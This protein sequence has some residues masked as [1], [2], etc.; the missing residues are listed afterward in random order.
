[1]PS[2]KANKT[3]KFLDIID[4]KPSPIR[5]V[6]YD[7]LRFLLVPF[8]DS[9]ELLYITEHLPIIT[10]TRRRYIPTPEQ[11]L[12]FIRLFNY[13]WLF[14]SSVL[15]NWYIVVLVFLTHNQKSMS[16]LTT[17]IARIASRLS[18]HSISMLY[19][20]LWGKRPIPSAIARARKIDFFKKN[21]YQ[22]VK[23]LIPSATLALIWLLGS[24][25]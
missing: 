3:N 2:L 22:I 1:M 21:T 8:N 19:F 14:Q 12:E 18:A 7:G 5:V 15:F 4:A 9:W 16:L 17:S 25:V 24:L 6:Y 11:A 13:Y 10:N 23:E 20:G